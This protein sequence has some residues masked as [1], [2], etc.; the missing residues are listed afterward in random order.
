VSG[1]VIPF[2]SGLEPETHE[3]RED[4]VKKFEELLEQ[5]RSGE[6]QGAAYAVL[7]PGGFSAYNTIGRTTR[8]LLG[9]IDLLKYD[10]C[11]ADF[12]KDD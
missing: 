9:A 7:H 11:R 6:I 2:R 10:M 5:A 8:G 1:S 4:V 3:P 12:Q